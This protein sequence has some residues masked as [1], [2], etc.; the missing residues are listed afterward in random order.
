M[1]LYDSLLLHND[2]YFVLKDF[3]TYVKAHSEID[4]LFRQKA[5]WQ[6][7]S[8]INIAKSGIF[9]SDN[10]IKKYAKEIWDTPSVNIKIL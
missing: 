6:Q 9:S 1:G 2:E 7:M 4:R 5:I 3:D 10:T 8:I